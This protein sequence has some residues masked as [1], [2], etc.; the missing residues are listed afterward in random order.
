VFQAHQLA[1]ENAFHANGAGVLR[2]DRGRDDESEKD[3]D[4][5]PVL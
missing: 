2:M 5:E 4:Q 3:G 1:R